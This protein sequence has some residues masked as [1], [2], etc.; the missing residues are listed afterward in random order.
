MCRIWTNLTYI[1]GQEEMLKASR[2]K[3]VYK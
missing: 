3:K 1:D 2:W